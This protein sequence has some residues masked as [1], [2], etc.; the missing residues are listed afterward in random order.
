M[1][2]K[3]KTPRKRCNRCEHLVYTYIPNTNKY[4]YKCEITGKQHSY[5]DLQLCKTF[6]K[7]I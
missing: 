7:K 1:L 3:R 6:K 5:L 4:G 2:K